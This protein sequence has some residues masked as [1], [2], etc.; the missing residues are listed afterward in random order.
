[1]V[2]EHLHKNA[3]PIKVKL[4]KGQK[5]TYGWEISIQGNEGPKA[6]ADAL[7]IDAALRTEFKDKLG[8]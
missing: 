7:A 2:T 5:D 8:G 6:M 1:M 3:D 4:I